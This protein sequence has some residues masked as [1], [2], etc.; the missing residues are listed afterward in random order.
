PGRAPRRPCDPAPR[1]RGAASYA[2]SPCPPRAE[3]EDQPCGVSSC[4]PEPAGR[5]RGF[6]RFLVEVG[7]GLLI[8]LEGFV[9]A[10]EFGDRALAIALDDGALRGI[11]TGR[12]VGRQAVDPALHRV[13]EHLVALELRVEFLLPTRPVL[14]VPGRAAVLRRVLGLVIGRRSRRRAGSI[15]RR[16]RLDDPRRRA[17]VLVGVG[18]RRLLDLLA[19]CFFFLADVAE[20][21]R[22]RRAHRG[23]NAREHDYRGEKG[24]YT[25]GVPFYRLERPST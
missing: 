13:G 5:H 23:D 7:D 15:R 20:A 9:Q 3:L 24:W 10:V 2:A 22:A 25:H 18:L 6:A 4:S 21:L 11:G 17:K 1:A 14:L 12:E 16:R 8:V 19:P